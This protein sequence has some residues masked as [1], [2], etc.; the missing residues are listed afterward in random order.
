MAKQKI[1]RNP[2]VASTQDAVSTDV[3][4]GMKRPRAIVGKYDPVKARI[5][6]KIAT[7]AGG[8]GEGGGR[9]R[10]A[11]MMIDFVH[12]SA[13]Y[14]SGYKLD[15]YRSSYAFGLG[16]RTGAYDV[17]TYFL[18]MNQQNGGLLYWPVTLAEKYSWYR[19]FC[20]YLDDNHLGQVLMSDGTLKSIK[21]VQVGDEV[22]T[23][24]GSVRRVAEK[25]ERQCKDSKAVEISA[26]CLQ[27]TAL[28]THEHPFYILKKS[29]VKKDEG[30]YRDQ[31]D[32]SPEWVNA[33]RIEVGD[34]VLMAPYKPVKFSQM[35][36]EQT[37]FLGYYA[38]EGS[39]VWGMRCVNTTSDDGDVKVNG[40]KWH[41]E[42][43]KVPIGV[44]FTLHKDEENS[45]G[46]K[47]LELSSS[48]FGVN[49]SIVRRRENH[50]EILVSG[51]N[52]GEFCHLHVGSYSAEKKLSKDLLDSTIEAKKSFLLAYAEGDGHQYLNGSNK[53][54]LLIATASN[55][56]AS[57]V[58]LLAISA[59]VMCRIA[60]YE[61]KNDKWSDNPIWHIT[62]PSWS[63]DSLITGSTK[64]SDSGSD[65]DKHCAFFINGY[66]AFKID[67]ISYMEKDDI[68]YNLELDAEGDEKS[69]M[70]NGMVTHNCR[71]DAYIGRA[72]E[73]L[74]DL[75]MSKIT[76]NMPKMP[77]AK[78]ALQKEIQEF[79]TYQL[80]AIN[81]FD[82]CQDILWEYNMIG[83]CFPA[84]HL[85]HTEQGMMPICQ[86]RENDRVL[87][88]SGQYGRVNAISRRHVSEWLIDLDIARLPAIEFTPT[89]EHPVFILRNGQEK[90]VPAKE[91][92]N[93]DYIGIAFSTEVKDIEEYDIRSEILGILSNRYDSVEV[94]NLNNGIQVFVSHKT[95]TGGSDTTNEI[96]DKLIAW[97]SSLVEPVD[98]TCESVSKILGTDNI[99]RMRN[100]AYS[101]R[102]RGVIRTERGRGGHHGSSIRWFPVSEKK[103]APDFY[104]RVFNKTF[105][106]DM[107]SVCVDDEFM[108]LLGYW[109]GDGW[110]WNNKR[111][112][113]YQYSTFDICIARD[114]P[115][116]NRLCSVMESVF[117]CD[118]FEKGIGGICN[119]DLFHVLVNDPIFCSW[120]AHHFGYDCKSKRIPKWVMELPP[121]KQIWLLRGM[122]DSDGF[123]S[124][125][126][127]EAV[128]GITNTND[129]LMHQLFQLGIRCGIPFCFGKSKQR[130]IEM[131][132]G[133]TA[134]SEIYYL[135]VSEPDHIRALTEG[136]VKEI[137]IDGSSSEHRTFTYEI[138]DGKFYFKV[139]N[140]GR[141]Y[142]DGY[143]YN[144]EVDGEHT[145]C[146]NEIRTHN[147]Y[148]FLEW[149]D[150]KKMWSRAVML[151]PE[152][153]YIFQYPFSDN[154]RVE[155]RPE[156]LVKMIR[157]GATIV[158]GMSAT[159]AMEGNTCARAD[160]E[161]KILENLPQELVEMVR[162]EGCIVMDTDPT[163]GSF[164]HHFARRRSPYMD[165]GVSVLERVL[166]P[167][168]QK[169]HYKYCQLSLASRNMT[170]KNL[171]SA[172][173]LMPEEVDALRTQVDLS[174]LDP[175]YSVIT[176]Y[177]INWEQIGTTDR[178][179]DLD[180][181]YE[182]IENQ[183]FAALGVTRELLT[184]EGTFTGGKVTVE[185]LNTMFLMSREI[186]KNFIEKKLFI[187]ICEAHGWYEE[188]KNGIRKYIYPQV[189]FNRLTIRDNAEVFDS[190]FQLYQKGSLPVDIL[191]ELFNLNVDEINNKLRNQLFT[192]KDATSN[193]M[194][195]EVNAEVGRKLVD[196]TDIVERV[197]RYLGVKM[198]PQQQDQAGGMGGGGGGFQQGF[199][200]LEGEPGTAPTG[201]SEGSPVPPVGD[202]AEEADGEP[203]GK[204]DQLAEA[205]AE[206]LPPEAD[207]NDVEQIVEKVSEL[208]SK[209]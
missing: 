60:K 208:E 147:C 3:V 51:R 186:L 112:T 83:N 162:T 129:S 141:K 135:K 36:C 123:I 40:W 7:G 154:K 122:I 95:P 104:G 192:V 31:M 160:L 149:S 106:S 81:A 139:N 175:E 167:M 151:P 107:V 194:S 41:Q 176:N 4:A 27:N 101:L 26:W 152:E 172:P 164:V 148:V 197:A 71:S 29:Q 131:P 168:L 50:I 70:C 181:E 163:T 198:K 91:I 35:T 99:V 121:S 11:G 22:I 109:M 42:K 28:V 49:G 55:D 69:Y 34:Y 97:M 120:W 57:Q 32:F 150:E 84:G 13:P 145:Y 146:T 18:M 159:S 64:W 62:I 56:L 170:P 132:R 200:D 100:V 191:Y 157:D 2:I 14:S 134:N 155:Y 173:G 66:A 73:L 59:G 174:Y 19:Y 130:D 206:S 1:V 74:T 205:I 114:T 116:V 115:Q 90:M 76:L 92:R 117:G 165:L 184:G 169:E 102:K 68:V 43:T 16:D 24:V 53:G 21:D 48:V 23:G 187:P 103:N 86:I 77:K 89:S 201:E 63:A 136:C 166:V 108:Y 54:K 190:L 128:A 38:S 96:K 44:S 180:R 110:I 33:D 82:L 8:F 105:D 196:A 47:I 204:T 111:P 142:H 207:E 37:S 12:M 126:D 202:K 39:I 10:Q 25:I 182:R 72:L 30:H 183:V 127:R 45:V 185:I 161:Q 158:A 124:K 153:V 80:D 203:K 144:F 171:I 17:P 177:E 125:T 46:K 67:K 118:G 5:A 58:Q 119:D 209:E 78:R 195:E 65:G 178:L 188:G 199:T 113:S 179:I 15:T 9:E 143:V 85:V 133:G 156:R 88:A 140:I 79:F 20:Y 87:T 94:K 98:M 52:V 75:P 189:G 138:K 93:D 6:K 137:E 61:R 193:R